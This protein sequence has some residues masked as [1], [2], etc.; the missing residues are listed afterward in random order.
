MKK[1]HFLLEWIS[2]YRNALMGMEILTIIVFHIVNSQRLIGVHYIRMSRY[3]YEYIGSSGVDVFLLLSGFGLY[4]SWKKNQ[5]LIVFYKKRFLRIF[6]PYIIV[7]LV[8]WTIRDL[9]LCELDL[10]AFIKDITFITFFTKGERWFW[11]ILMAAACYFVF[12]YVYDLIETAE[13]Y[14]AEQMRIALIIVFCTGTVVLFDLYNKELYDCLS[15]AILRIPAFCGGCLLGKMAYEK[16][17]LTRWNVWIF[18]ILSVVLVGP[19]R[20]RFTK[21]VMRYSIAALNFSFCLIAICLLEYFK[22][23]IVLRRIV[24]VVE[25]MLNVCGKYSLELY[26]VHVL[27]YIVLGKMGYPIAY[28]RYCLIMI[29]LM[30]P[31]SV[32]L[33]KIS[34]YLIRKCNN[35]FFCHKDM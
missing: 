32:A 16:R 6:V 9:I 12:P 35:I 34:E 25:N 27:L 18:V 33:K 2:R 21:I 30:I 7:A 28:L 22:C 24:H 13:N 1:N 5:N 31:L 29:L 10:V 4:F 3:I 11:Y 8:G 26:L 23:N 17:K 15:I 14:I 20:L 19:F